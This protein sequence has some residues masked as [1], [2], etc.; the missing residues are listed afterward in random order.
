LLTALEGVTR[1][2]E[3]HGIPF[4]EYLK[5]RGGPA[6][7]QFPLYRVLHT[8]RQVKTYQR[9]FYDEREYDE[10]VN[11][12][13]EQLTVFGEELEIIEVDDYEGLARARGAP[14]T[15]RPR[16]FHQAPRSA[17]LVSEIEGYGI[18]LDSL[19]PP[20]GEEQPS[21]KFSI[22][23]NGEIVNV[24]ALREV[25][26]AVK[27]LGRKGLEIERFKGLGEM[28]AAELA[29]TTLQPGSRT[30]VQVTVG[31]AI[32]ADRYFSI[33]AGKDVKKRREFI[34]GHALEAHNLDV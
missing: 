8:D 4:P 31:D 12:L 24:D 18:P 25:V 20:P 29:E 11:S 34:E 26:P 13:Q 10:F 28:D 7:N 6:G 27:Q 19:V 16:K 14:N 3:Q 1:L 30:M 22:I 5:L 23:S 9:F 21:V 32:K 2:V 33:L 15:L 17:Q